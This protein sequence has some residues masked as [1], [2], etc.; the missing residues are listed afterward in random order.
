[1]ET[2]GTIIELAMIVTTVILCGTVGWLYSL[3]VIRKIKSFR[4]K[5]F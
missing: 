5:G 4:K 2:I 1:M 3:D